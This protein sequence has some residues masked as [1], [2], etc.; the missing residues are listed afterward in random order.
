LG[1]GLDDW[2]PKEDTVPGDIDALARE[3]VAA[4]KAKD[5]VEADRLRA[6]LRDA[7]W[8]MEDGPD[9]YLLRRR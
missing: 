7:G 1:L 2:R 3:R 5:W 9:G 8:D 6:L 4:R